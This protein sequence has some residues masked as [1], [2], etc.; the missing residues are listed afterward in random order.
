M[1]LV[2]LHFT[3]QLS[4]Y[5]YTSCEYIHFETKEKYFPPARTLYKKFL[6]S[7]FR[8]KQLLNPS[9]TYL[10]GVQVYD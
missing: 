9:I 2:L 4:M 5:L 1:F 6:D 7:I 3:S 10:T 8:R